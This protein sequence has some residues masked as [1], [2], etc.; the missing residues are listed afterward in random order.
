MGNFQ[1]SI[2]SQVLHSEMTSCLLHDAY[3]R[4][5][6]PDIGDVVLIVLA[7][8]YIVENYEIYA[9]VL[10]SVCCFRK[11]SLIFVLSHK[12]VFFH[13]TR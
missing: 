9:C 8:I 3:Y 11:F 6:R 7:Y 1:C 2:D 10:S 5:V 13:G 12:A 4:V